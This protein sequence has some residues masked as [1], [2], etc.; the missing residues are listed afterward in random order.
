MEGIFSRNGRRHFNIAARLYEWLSVNSPEGKF[1]RRLTGFASTLLIAVVAT[2]A[3]IVPTQEALAKG[4]EVASLDTQGSQ[5]VRDWFREYDKIR[6]DAEM[7]LSEKLQSRSFL[8]KGL[9]PGADTPQKITDLMHRMNSKYTTAHHAMEHLQPVAETKSLQDGYTEY[10]KR[11]RHLFAHGLNTEQIDIGAT[12]SFAAKREE[13]EIL[14]KR[15]KSL[16]ASLRKRFKI[17]RH[18]ANK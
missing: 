7:S 12:I 9:K 8:Q 14:D 13:I 15:N 3:V 18:G 5:S 17:P 11:M 1:F 6:S 16:D 10:F 2:E 4:Q